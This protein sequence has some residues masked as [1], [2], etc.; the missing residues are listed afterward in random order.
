MKTVRCGK[1][2]SRQNKQKNSPPLCERL[3]F[4]RT[5]FSTAARSTSDTPL[6]G[7]HKLSETEFPT[8]LTISPSAPT[9]KPQKQ[10]DEEV[11]AFASRKLRRCQIPNSEPELPFV[12]EILESLKSFEG[13]DFHFTS[14]LVSNLSHHREEEESSHWPEIYKTDFC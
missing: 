5:Y 9:R 8:A 10:A 11:A 7:L 3:N 13:L 14:Q 6:V 1:T 4:C 12:L 2:D